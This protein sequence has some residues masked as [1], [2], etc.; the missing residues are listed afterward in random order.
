M[1][2]G[3]KFLQFYIAQVGPGD[4][5][6]TAAL[7]DG[8]IVSRWELV[9]RQLVTVF[10]EVLFQ[11]CVYGE[12]AGQKQELIPTD[13][14]LQ[15]P[16]SEVSFVLPQWDQLFAVDSAFGKVR[17]VVQQILGIPQSVATRELTNHQMAAAAPEFLQ[18]QPAP[19]SRGGGRVADR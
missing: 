18:A 3:R 10:G 6:E 15:L 5:G 17:D 12:R 8:R 16:D 14:R 9:R 2:M 13:Q 4:V 7:D 11:R 19:R 1:A